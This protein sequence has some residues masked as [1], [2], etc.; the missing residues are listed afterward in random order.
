M[1]DRLVDPRLPR[2]Q[3]NLASPVVQIDAAARLLLKVLLLNLPFIDQRENQPIDE[4]R[5]EDLRKIQIQAEP[6]EVRLVQKA[7]ARVQVRP[8]DLRKRQNVDLVL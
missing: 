7:D 6:T 8:I 3:D 5:L 2:A 1:L 4:D